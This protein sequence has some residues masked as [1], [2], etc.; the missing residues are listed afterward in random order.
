[1]LEK[2]NPGAGICTKL[3]AASTSPVRPVPPLRITGQN[4]AKGRRSKQQ[5]IALAEAL[6]AGKVELRRPT[7]KQ[8]AAVTQ[9]SLAEIYRARQARKPKPQPPSLAE[10]LAQASPVERVEAA[11]AFGVA[12]LWDEFVLPLVGQAA[13]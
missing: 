10:H 8:S 6:H 1:M 12:R 11:R 3:A 9:V 7:W 13:E 5:R 2:L 4:I